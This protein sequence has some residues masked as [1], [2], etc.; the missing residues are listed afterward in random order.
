MSNANEYPPVFSQEKIIILVSVKE[1][2]PVGFQ[3]LQISASD[4][5]K[6]PDGEVYYSCT[7]ISRGISL[8]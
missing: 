2:E 5:D 4:K 8:S 3:I 7:S 6:G 1:S